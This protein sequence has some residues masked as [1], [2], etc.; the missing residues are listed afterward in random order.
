MSL[1]WKGGAGG[2]SG[3]QSERGSYGTTRCAGNCRDSVSRTSRTRLTVSYT[4]CEG[5]WTALVE[6]EMTYF[7]FKLTSLMEDTFNPGL[8][9]VS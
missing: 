4:P 5:A 1:A 7:V 3:G 8:V 2:C 6:C 9:K